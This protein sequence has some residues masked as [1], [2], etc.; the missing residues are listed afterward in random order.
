IRVQASGNLQVVGT[1]TT[2]ITTT[3][4]LYRGTT[5]IGKLALGGEVPTAAAAFTSNAFVALEW[6]DGPASVSAQTY[7]VKIQNSANTASTSGSFPTAN[8]GTI[9]L[10]EIQG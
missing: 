6:L 1:A 9:I 10:E 7:S 5:A 2:D 3:A 4:Q 8:G